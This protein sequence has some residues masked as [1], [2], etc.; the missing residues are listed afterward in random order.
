M[1]IIFI[2]VVFVK[3]HSLFFTHFI[4]GLYFRKL[5]LL[6]EVHHMWVSTKLCFLQTDISRKKT[7][8]NASVFIC[9]FIKLQI[10]LWT[11]GLKAKLNACGFVACICELKC[12][13][14]DL[15]H[16]FL[17]SMCFCWSVASMC[18]RL[19]YCFRSICVSS[20]VIVCSP[21]RRL[22]ENRDH[23]THVHIGF[24][25]GFLHNQEKSLLKHLKNWTF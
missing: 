8:T 13:C 15:L 12:A 16:I 14:M 25:P 10:L 5:I 18:W 17:D 7:N 6:Q 11:F 3:S 2:H 22:H 9:A 24:P 4:N 1:A 20:T 23:F 19:W 21:A